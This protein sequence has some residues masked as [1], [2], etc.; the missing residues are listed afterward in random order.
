[1]RI[2]LIELGSPRET[3]S[4]TSWIDAEGRF[5]M[6]AVGLI[7]IASQT[8][9]QDEIVFI[10]EKV[11]PLPESLDADLVAISFKTMEC[12]RAYRLADSL[13]AEGRRVVLGG[14]HVSLMPEEA[15]AHA[16]AVIVGEG[17][18]L[19]ARVLDEIERGEHRPIYRPS[20]QTRLAE[21]PRQRVELIDH[22]RY[23]AH[24]LQSA[25]GCSFTCEFCPT[26]GIFG[27]GYRL[28]DIDALLE[29]V[30]ALLAI[31]DKPIFF[32]ENVFG[33]GDPEF[34]SRLTQALKARSIRYGAI[35]D[36]FMLTPTTVR[37]LEEGGCGLVCVNT[38]GRDE[39]KEIAALEAFYEA[40]IPIWGYFMFGF[41]EDDP[42]VFERA[43]ERARRYDI[44]TA[45]L[46][47]LTPFPGTPMASR[48]AAEGRIFS[49]DLSLYDHGH[50]HFE[51]KQMSAEALTQG[52]DHVCSE[53]SDR[54]RFDAAVR[55]L[56]QG[57][58]P[59]RRGQ[60]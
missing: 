52:F 38:T 15:A 9:P 30:E 4:W 24:G 39:P 28:R 60:R 51:P 20:E 36:W 14:V 48:L 46:T 8:R 43:I 23:M 17:E 12:A 16:D 41:E 49:D 44:V 45:T 32:T 31:E 7:S 25:R 35:C 56:A 40:G 50:V 59:G 55:V 37:L 22:P 54:L 33:A 13:R 26:R 21:L 27:S 34:I 58:S 6:P 42:S 10:D 53:L 3:I 5:A 47:V 29:E 19:W 11:S 57:S 2:I 1:M 18:G